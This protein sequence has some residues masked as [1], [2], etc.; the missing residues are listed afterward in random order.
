MSDAASEEYNGVDDRVH[1]K[2]EK[3]KKVVDIL[4][5]ALYNNYCVTGRTLKRTLR[6]VAQLG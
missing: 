1:K 5:D 6:G 3:I 4:F 2:Y